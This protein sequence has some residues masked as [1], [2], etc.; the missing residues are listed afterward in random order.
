MSNK[1]LNNS[2][3]RFIEFAGKSG[4]AAK[5]LQG[6]SL[7]AG[8]L[9][10]RYAQAS[11]GVKRVVFVYTPLGSPTNMWLPQ[12]GVMNLATQAYEGLQPVC[13]FHEADVVAA[14]FGQMWKALGE[15]RYTSDWTGDTIDHQI[16][17]V[18]GVSTPFSTIPFGVQ[19]GVQESV[20]RKN[21]QK[22]LPLDGPKRTYDRLF[23]PADDAAPP[24]FIAH[25]R[26]QNVMD[27]HLEALNCSWSKLSSD[28]VR[29]IEQ[30]AASLSTF[31]NKL[32]DSSGASLPA[33][34]RPDW[35][36]NGYTVQTG[37]ERGIFAHEAYLQAEIISHAFSCGLTNVATLQ[38]S[39]QE[40]NF[41]AHDVDFQGT[42]HNAT[43]SQGDQRVYAQ[44]ANYLSRCVAHLIKQLAAQDDPAVPGTKLLDNTLVL[45][46]SDIGHGPTHSGT[47]GPTLIATG[48]SEFKTGLAT[49][50][51]SGND[52]NWRVLQTVAAGLGL[53]EYIGKQSHHCI[54]PCG[55]GWGG[56]NT[57][58]LS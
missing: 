47:R 35:N 48:L 44:M 38:L 3:R 25:D 33:C 42:L 5:A 49:P 37:E 17:K 2:R 31:Q 34:H 10:N 53:E 12:K 21:G 1:T 32:N 55:E 22:V 52:V 29:T 57:D 46:V 39:D 26:K 36:P 16:A 28:E 19:A 56:V 13:H 4:I 18:L 15:I 20:S 43:C 40:G 54:W 24:N 9:A 27:A 14:G 6:S 50:M 58:L 11:N 8:L 41:R 23:G 45:Q 51:R 30:Y 7:L